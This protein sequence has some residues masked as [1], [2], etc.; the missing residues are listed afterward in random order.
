MTFREYVTIKNPVGSNVRVRSF[1][2]KYRLDEN[3][4]LNGRDGI[5]KRSRSAIT[6]LQVKYKGKYN[7]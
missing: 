1:I 6:N 4:D 7:K 2:V 5:G 3:S